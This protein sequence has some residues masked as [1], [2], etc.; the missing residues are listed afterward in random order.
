L[1]I[2]QTGINRVIIF[3]TFNKRGRTKTMILSFIKLIPQPEKRQAMIDILRTMEA[4]TKIK[5]GC[6]CCCI[7]EQA[8]ERHGVLYVERWESN[9]A[10]NIHVQSSMYM[11]LLTAMELACEAPDIQFHY[12]EKTMGIELIEALRAGNG[13]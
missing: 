5:P 8:D 4:L 1:V 13:G 7:Y 10:L 9:E 2:V 6:L 11:R 3:I 12:V